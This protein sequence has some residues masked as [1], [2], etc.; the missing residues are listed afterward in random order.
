MVTRQ[1]GVV[2]GDLARSGAIKTRTILN[3]CLEL[4]KMMSQM[5]DGYDNKN[6]GAAYP[7]DVARLT[8]KCRAHHERLT[9]SEVFGHAREIA[10][11]GRRVRSSLAK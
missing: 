9:H 2:Y 11:A 4:S 7:H 1:N 3:G 5:R 6:G 10:N 8:A